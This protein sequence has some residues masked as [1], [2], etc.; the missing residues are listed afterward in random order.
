MSDSARISPTAHYTGYVWAR[1]GLSHPELSTREG[2][3]LYELVRPAMLASRAL[4][5]AQLEPYLLARHRA[6]DALLEQAIEK[7]GVSQVIEVAC[8]LSPRGWRF[9]GRYGARI[10]Y[11]EADLPGV[12]E[13]KREALGRMGSLGAHHRVEVLDALREGGPQSL[14]E[15][16]GGLPRREGLAIITDG[17]LGYLPGDEVEGLWRRFAA[18][19]A[20]FQAGFYLS[21]LH[22]GDVQ[23]L[24]VRAFRVVLSAFVRGQ[25]YL[26]WGTAAQAREA[27]LAAGFPAAELHRAVA[28]VPEARGPGAGMAHI[29]EASTA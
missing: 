11:I 23:T 10:T 12:A 18:T 4:G 2:R 26:H 13:L 21:D 14:A 5:G 8:G 19:L 9:A 16:A 6:I 1:H 28:L 3:A 17:L 27:L 20:R 25:V 7:H 24:Q 29:I 15:L 22:V